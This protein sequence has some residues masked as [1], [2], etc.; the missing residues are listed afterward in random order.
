MFYGDGSVP[1]ALGWLVLLGVGL[2]SSGEREA[3]HWETP[4]AFRSWLLIGLEVYLYLFIF[5]FT[6]E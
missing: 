4:P 2:P 1:A 5:S 3:E 6:E